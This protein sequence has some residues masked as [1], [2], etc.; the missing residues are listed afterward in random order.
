MSDPEA[1]RQ[2]AMAAVRALF[3]KYELLE[4]R[5]PKHHAVG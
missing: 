1:D 3:E 5:R 2:K 4:A